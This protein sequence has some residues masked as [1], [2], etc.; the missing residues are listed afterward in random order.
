MMLKS[1]MPMFTEGSPAE[2]K[3]ESPKKEASEQRKRGTVGHHKV[4]AQKFMKRANK[5]MRMA[6]KK[7]KH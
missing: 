6:I 2:E 1:S 5:H 4:M 3:G 7:A